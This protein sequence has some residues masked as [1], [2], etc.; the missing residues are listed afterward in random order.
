MN[1]TSYN[2]SDVTFH[3]I[4]LR[5][6]EALPSTVDKTTQT[7]TISK[8][9][10]SHVCHRSLRLMLPEP[11]GTFQSAGGKVC[12]ELRHFGFVSGKKGLPYRLTESGLATLALLEENRY[13]DLR[14]T[15]AEAHL[16]TYSNLRTVF[17][18]HLDGRAVWRPVV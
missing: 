18:H 13:S 4:G 14:K 11:K 2:I 15:M 5:V 1:I 16:K 9:I 17:L 10:Y 6:I 12:Q 7:D 3:Y 8:S